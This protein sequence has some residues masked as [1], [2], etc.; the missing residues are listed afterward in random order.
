MPLIQA[1]QVFI[2]Y[3]R[4]DQEYLEQLRKHLIPL[5]R[6]GKIRVWTD[7]NIEPGHL[8]DDSIKKQ[9]YQAGIILLLISADSLASDYFSGEEVRIAISRHEKG[10]AIVVP[11]I[12]KSCLWKETPL[13]AI[14]ALPKDGKPI[15]SWIPIDDAWEFVA[16]SISQMVEKIR[17]KEL[18]QD[19][20]QREQVKAE[21][22]V[23]QKKQQEQQ[24]KR[25]WAA[26][27][28]RLLTSPYLRWAGV[29]IA[30]L[31]LFFTFRNVTFNDLNFWKSAPREAATNP[32]WVEQTPIDSDRQENPSSRVFEKKDAGNTSNEPSVKKPAQTTANDPVRDSVTKAMKEKK[33]SL[34]SNPSKTNPTKNMTGGGSGGGS[35]LN[36]I[37]DIGAGLSGRKV[38]SRPRITDS[39]Q[40]EGRVVVEVCVDSKGN[41]ISANYTMRGS[42]TNDS[43]L[44]SKAISWARQYKF[45]PS[46]IERQCG[47]ITFNFQ[48]K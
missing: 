37:A 34:L 29:G 17:Q 32:S 14:Q 23:R 2:A 11:V 15:V 25:R 36:S 9:I 28:Y 20:R 6:N 30:A 16:K 24:L 22:R 26:F 41:V 31:F 8:W 1:V 27:R 21:E 40:R 47:I 48:L 43:E 18:R 35:G 4:L 39:P 45:E 12:L 38:L 33:G 10:E 42:T 46:S 5:E 13:A 7:N 19:E 44:R 3:S